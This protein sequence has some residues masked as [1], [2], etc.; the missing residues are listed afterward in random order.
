[1]ILSDFD[2]KTYIR[3]G[4]LKIDPLYDDTIQQNGVDLHLAGEI[5]LPRLDKGILDLAKHDPREWFRIERS[6]NGITIP[7]KTSA[8][9]TTIE[10]VEMPDDLMAICGLR[11]TIARLGFTSPTTYVDAGF[12]GQLTIEVYW[13]HDFPIRVYP[14]IRFLHVIFLK[15]LNKVEKPYRGV[16]QWQE[17]VRPPK[18]LIEEIEAFKRLI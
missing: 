3:E 11:S 12:K 13:S 5:G 17:G 1:M 18:P 4:R 10:V 2:L 15:C 6:E 9:F 16:Y 14:G 8:L 7:P